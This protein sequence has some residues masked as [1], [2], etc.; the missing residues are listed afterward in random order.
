[1]FVTSSYYDCSEIYVLIFLHDNITEVASNKSSLLLK[2]IYTN[3]HTF[4]YLQWILKE[5][6]FTK[7]IKNAM[8]QDLGWE[9]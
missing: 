9:I 4:H 2:I 8:R 6:L 1:M 3:T 7:V 5:K